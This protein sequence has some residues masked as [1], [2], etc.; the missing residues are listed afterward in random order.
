MR[1]TVGL[2]PLLW[3]CTVWGVDGSARRGVVPT[4]DAVTRTVARAR[5]I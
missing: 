1:I 3:A 4:I 5:S 2:L